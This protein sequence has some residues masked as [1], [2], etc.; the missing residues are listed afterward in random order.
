MVTFSQKKEGSFSD[1]ATG[2]QLR[3]EYHIAKWKSEK[4]LKTEEVRILTLFS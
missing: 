1:K 2:R 3:D 4:V